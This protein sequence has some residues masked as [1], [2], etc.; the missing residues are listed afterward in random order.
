MKS[1]DGYREIWSHLHNWSITLLDNKS[2]ILQ[3]FPLRR[4]EGGLSKYKP[5]CTKT[6]TFSNNLNDSETVFKKIYLKAWKREK[7]V[8]IG[9]PFLVSILP[10]FVSCDCR[11]SLKTKLS[12]MGMAISYAELSV[13]D[14]SFAYLKLMAVGTRIWA[15]HECFEEWSSIFPFTKLYIQQIWTQTT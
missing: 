3:S 4:E 5:S 9:N 11:G 14:S 10:S 13:S 15:W 6:V 2:S 1:W 12:C 8:Y 7:R